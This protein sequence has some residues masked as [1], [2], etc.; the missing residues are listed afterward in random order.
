VAISTAVYGKTQF[1]FAIAKESTF[2]TAITAD[3]SFQELH[4]T[5]PPTL[6][7]ASAVVT[8]ETPRIDGSAVLSRY[9][10]YK[11][12]AGAITTVTVSGILTK[13]S[14]PLLIYG[15][16][17]N[18]TEGAATPYLKTSTWDRTTVPEGD[19]GSQVFFTLALHDPV[20]GEAKEVTSAFLKTLELTWDAASNGG[21]VAFN[22]TFVSGLQLIT[23]ANYTPGSWKGV[24]SDFFTL[25]DLDTKT[26]AGSDVV[27]SNFSLSI[28]NGATFY[29][30]DASGYAEG[31]A[32]GATG[33]KGFTASGSITVKYDANTKDLF[34]KALA[35]PT[36]AANTADLE[37]ILLWLTTGD[38]GHLGFTCNAVLDSANYNFGSDVGV[39][40]DLP[41]KCVDDGTATAA[42]VL[43]V[44]DDTDRTW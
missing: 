39:M 22:A 18:V 30:V 12:Q 31:C 44:A 24:S 8:D 40:R 20:S 6:D 16:M 11:T 23:T 38:D 33:G 4:I 5:E 41:F 7:T 14:A 9:D 29:G 27:A 19:E 26:V 17:Q 13:E 32:V 43:T 37:I 34:D 21:R 36:T 42:L 25:S 3:A 35:N 1:R 2:G 15:A 28:D 10:I